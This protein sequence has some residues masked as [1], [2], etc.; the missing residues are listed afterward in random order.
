[1][2]LCLLPLLAGCEPEVE[3]PQQRTS[4]A[5]QAPPSSVAPAE[6]VPRE[7][8]LLLRAEI[9]TPFV[10]SAVG[11]AAFELTLPE[12]GEFASAALLRLRDFPRR[13]GACTI[14]SAP[15]YEVAPLWLSGRREGDRLLLRETRESR[16]YTIEMECDELPVTT[17][18]HVPASE[19]E[20]EMR[21]REGEV[22]EHRAPGERPG[23]RVLY[24]YTLR[25]RALVEE[26]IAS[27]ARRTTP[28]DV[29]EP[30][31]DAIEGIRRALTGDDPARAIDLAVRALG[32]GNLGLELTIVPDRTLEDPGAY[33]STREGP[34]GEITVRL[35]P[36]A[37]RDPAVLLSTILH[38][39]IGHGVLGSSELDPAFA[40]RWPEE[41][42]AALWIELSA[43]AALELPEED[44]ARLLGEFERRRAA[45][46]VHDPAAALELMRRLESVEPIRWN[47]CGGE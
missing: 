22:H 10:G 24:R 31:A 35:A 3:R 36:A 46:S 44:Q 15:G 37:L 1:M 45:L 5:P 33:G 34:G 2:G 25:S 12:D 4:A 47:S 28:I 40:S 14:I 19:H 18:V 29:C 23:E 8:I 38:E 30:S 26:R 21:V 39:V 41:E 42:V 7:W 20:F 27:R 32:L 16:D 17:P 13:M 11:D 43:A 6:A 9:E